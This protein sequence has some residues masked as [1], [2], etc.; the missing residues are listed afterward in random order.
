LAKRGLIISYYFPPTGG[1][2]VQRWVKLLKYLSEY[3]W[4]FCVLAN[5]HSHSSP[6]DDSLL[7]EVSDKTFVIRT[8]KF[9]TSESIQ[10]KTPFLNQ[11]GYWQRWASA[12]IRIT[13]SRKSWNKIAREYLK[14]ELKRNKYD[15]IIFTS[16]PYSLVLLAA[17]IKQEVSCP[18][19]LDLRDPW[20]I[21]PYKIYPTK[22]HRLL[23]EQ[24]ER[25]SI[26]KIDHFISAYQSTIDDYSK[27]IKNFK[28]KNILVLPNG[29]DETDFDHLKKVSPFDGD[30]Y[31]L[32]FSGSIYSHLNTPSPVF[33]A[34]NRLKSEGIDVHFHHI[35]TSVYDLKKLAKKFD[36]E[37]RIHQ[38]GYHNHIKNLEILNMMDALCI[39]LDDHWPNSEHTVGGKFYEYL[40]L[41]KPIFAVVPKCGEAAELINKTN[42]GVVASAKSIDEITQ[43]LKTLILNQQEFTWK[44]IDEFN[45][46]RQAQI[47]NNFLDAH[48]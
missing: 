21:N 5:E 48:I 18:V 11:S 3:G 13:D 9:S 20:T 6:K 43:K 44:G 46:A 33:K 16:P 45:R 24:R 7:S 32:G 17:E 2:G 30:N 4:E 8:E 47:L 1:G 29:Y 15:A 38:W 35:G 28:S 22:I 26:S 12:F 14:K 40:R 25:K 19:F 31:N 39:I 42:S 36:I 27:R 10:S 37:D 23:D 41:K 34:M